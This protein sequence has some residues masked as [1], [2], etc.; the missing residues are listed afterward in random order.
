MDMWKVKIAEE[1]YEILR[2]TPAFQ[3]SFSKIAD[4]RRFTGHL[5]VAASG[6]SDIRGYYPL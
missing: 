1:F 6:R 2:K 3:S 4:S 5:R